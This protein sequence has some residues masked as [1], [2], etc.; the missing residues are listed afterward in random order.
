MFPCLAA[1]M[2]VLAGVATAAPLLRL[3]TEIQNRAF[4][5]AAFLPGDI[6]GDGIDDFLIVDQDER[7]TGCHG[8]ARVS[9]M[10]TIVNLL[11]CI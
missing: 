5:R 6:D 3:D 11:I 8:R 9:N 10:G 1:S 4:G 2:L 7:W